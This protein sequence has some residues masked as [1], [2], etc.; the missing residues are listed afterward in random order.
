MH[1]FA[2]NAFIKRYQKDIVRW[3]NKQSR[4]I[5]E[6]AIY[7]NLYKLNFFVAFFAAF[8]ESKNIN[9]RDTINKDYSLRVWLL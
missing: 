8:K 2:C 7:L 9:C 6:Y 1:N 3:Q 5:S 4:F